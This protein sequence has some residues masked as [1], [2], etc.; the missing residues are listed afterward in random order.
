[1]QVRFYHDGVVVQGDTIKLS[2]N[3]QHHLKNVLR[4]KEGQT[5]CYFNGSE[6]WECIVQIFG[7]KNMC[8]CQLNFLEKQK[9]YVQIHAF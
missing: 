4:I 2:T 5:V 1:M 3:G 9:K 8:C 7:K 6:E